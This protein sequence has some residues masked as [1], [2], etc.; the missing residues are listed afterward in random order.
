MNYLL[1]INVLL[2]FLL[3]QDRAD[4]VERFLKEAPH[5]QLVVTEFSIH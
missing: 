2:E 5:Q 1:D 3:D 4:E